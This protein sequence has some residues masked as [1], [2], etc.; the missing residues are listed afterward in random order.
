MKLTELEN[1]FREHGK[2]VGVLVFI[3]GIVSLSGFFMGMR[4]TDKEV[5][6]YRQPTDIAEYHS[7]QYPPAPKYSD[8]QDSGMLANADWNFDL[9]SLRE[10]GKMPETAEPLDADELA[11]I[12]KE[13][14]ERRAF[15]GAP[16]TIPHEIPQHS[17]ASCMT[18]HGADSTVQVGGVIPS[19]ISH[20]YFS[21]CTQCHVPADGLRQFTEDERSRLVVE[22][23]FSGLLMMGEGTRAFVGA[24]PT[25][26]HPLWMRQNC[27]SCHGPG[28]QHA[29]RTSHPTRGN[30]LQCHAP[31]G[32][33]D[34]R[35]RLPWTPPSP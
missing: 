4:Q 26:P 21:N 18:C 32:A 25:I 17:S 11:T 22:N 15:D 8:I 34:N 12:L 24:P 3:L 30:C 13:R 1:Y 20:P 10:R 2:L 14:A 6:V 35:E 31:N 29:I 9:S 5:G 27:M 28:R 33:L 23:D 16:P 7:D 19:Q